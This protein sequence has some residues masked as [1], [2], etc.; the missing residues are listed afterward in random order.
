[1]PNQK[2]K[3]P[4]MAGLLIVA[5]LATGV[6]AGLAAYVKYSPASRV[7]VDQHRPMNEGSQANEPTTKTSSRPASP[8][9]NETCWVYSP[10]YKGAELVLT[11]IEQPVPDGEDPI[12]FSINE[13][14]HNTKITSSDARLLSEHVKAGVVALSFN[15]A[16]A[17]TY[18]STDEGTL[19]NGISATLSQFPQI[20][21]VE[22]FADGKPID[23]LGNVDLSVPLDVTPPDGGANQKQPQP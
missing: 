6:V 7:P 22:Y 15:G 13:F 4:A 21:K 23:T 14:L 5:L 17:Q 19:L 2:T 8:K 3:K 1:M 20:K 9:S 12:V 10:S 11:K 16:F 18:G